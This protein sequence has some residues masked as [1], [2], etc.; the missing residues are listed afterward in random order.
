M[1]GKFPQVG[2]WICDDCDS[3][4][5]TQNLEHRMYRLWAPYCLHCDSD[6]IHFVEG[7]DD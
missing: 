6:N 2:H 4:Y 1:L 5:L 3:T 7:D